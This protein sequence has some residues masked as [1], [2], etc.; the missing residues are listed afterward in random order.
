MRRKRESGQ[1][2]IT[3]YKLPSVYRRIRRGNPKFWPSDGVLG[4]NPLSCK[5]PFRKLTHYRSLSWSGRV[6][7]E[8]LTGQHVR[9]HF[10]QAGMDLWGGIQTGPARWNP[11]PLCSCHR[12]VYP[13]CFGLR[14]GPVS[15]LTGMG[16]VF[17]VIPTN[18]LT[19]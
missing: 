16:P 18:T 1:A 19:R 17:N 12:E 10:C 2:E 4:S 6:L 14:S 7:E 13:L 11:F 5:R 9:R 15:G 8:L 3:P